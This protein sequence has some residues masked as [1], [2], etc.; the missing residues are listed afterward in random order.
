MKL[1]SSPS[2]ESYV[3]IPRLPFP[4]T[5][6]PESSD[7]T[8]ILNTPSPSTQTTDTSS[9][10]PAVPSPPVIHKG[11]SCDVC[12]K[13]IEG[14]RH[15]C[16]DCPGWVLF[17]LGDW[18]MTEY[19]PFRLWS[20]HSLYNGWSFWGSQS[21]PRIFRD[22]RTWA[23]HCTH[24]VQRGWW[25]GK[26]RHAYCKSSSCW[27]SCYWGNCCPLCQ[28]RPLWFQDSRR[29]LCKFFNHYQWSVANS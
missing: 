24:R 21:F 20:M 14:I 11:V 15:K 3:P 4:W 7:M 5:S 19:T 13:I 10:S 6:P 28:L 8:G 17:G 12:T 16:L 2:S 9:A 29:S 22:Q 27:S 25:K 23:S 1:A 26:S 18:N